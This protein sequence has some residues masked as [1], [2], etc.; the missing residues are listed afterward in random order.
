MHQCTRDNGP[1]GPMRWIGL[2]GQAVGMWCR[3]VGVLVADRADDTSRG[4]ARLTQRVSQL[5]TVLIACPQC[6]PE[7]TD[8]VFVFRSPA[9]HICRTYCIHARGVA[10]D[11]P[12]NIRCVTSIGAEA[13]SNPIAWITLLHWI[14]RAPLQPRLGFDVSQRAWGLPLLHASVSGTVQDGGLVKPSA[15]V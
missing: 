11:T 13:Q 7:S 6:S 3:S 9:P 10:S 14:D 12:G 1:G 5:L 15:V 2:L 8:V 4:M